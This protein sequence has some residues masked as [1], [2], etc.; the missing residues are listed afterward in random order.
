MLVDIG[1]GAVLLAEGFSF[2]EGPRWRDGSLYFSDFYTGRV[3]RWTEQAGVTTV[4]KIPGQPSGLGF[5]R[6]GGL[7]IVSMLD[8]RVLRFQDGA[9]EEH[10]S[11]QHVASFHCNDMVVDSLGRAYVGNFGS[12][13]DHEP[14]AETS[15]ALIDA[16]GNVRSVG[17]GLTFPNGMAIT[18]DGRTLYVGETFAH[19][20]TAF[21]I[22]IDGS[23]TGRRTLAD[24]GDG[25]PV[26]TVEQ[27]RA[28]GFPTPD[29]ICLDEEGS[30]WVASA[31]GPGIMRISATGV[32]LEAIETGELAAY[33]VM[34]GGHDR[35]TLFM[36]AAPP[37]GTFDPEQERRGVLLATR[38]PVAGAG[39]P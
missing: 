22:E 18:E 11:L 14:L 5:D 15:L 20:V 24:F 26:E 39:C 36:C 35:R 13:V 17:E 34:L 10:A 3:L 30:I 9:L 12:D 1:E 38:V 6:E 29:G 19:R 4:C 25:T 37:L 8:R 7:L 27:A 2:L 33:A 23:L 16:D 28:S 31:T 32:V 21:D